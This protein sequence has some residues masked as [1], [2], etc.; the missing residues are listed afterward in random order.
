MNA[1]D[2]GAPPPGATV[3]Q[4]RRDVP[5]RDDVDVLVVGGGLGGVSAALAA[6]RAGA[7]TTLVERNGFPGGVATAGMCCSVFNCFYTADRRLGIMGNAVEITDALAE[8]SGVGKAWHDHKG[9]VIYDV[10]AAKLTLTELL[11]QAGVR[12]LFDTVVTDA[13][14]DGD[15]LCGVFVHSKSGC[16]AI[17]SAVTVDAS[18]DAD[19]AWLAG[20]PLREMGRKA[21]HSYCF[22][23]GNVDVDAFVQY[24]VEHPDQYPD[25]MDVDWTFAEALEQYRATGTFLFPHG[26]GYQMDLFK[27]AVAS[28]ELPATV[29]MHDTIPACQMHAIRE[30]GVVHVIT[31][32]VTMDTMDV[33]TISRAMS[34]GKRMAFVVRDFFRQNVPGFARSCVIGLADDLGMRATRWIEGEF[35]FTRG[36]KENPTRFDDAI[37]RGVVERDVRKHQ[38]DDAWGVQTFTDATFDVPYRCLLPKQIDGLLMGAGRSISAE[39]PMLLRVMALT[40]VI[41]Q[42]AGVAA[43]VA[44]R[45]GVVPRQADVRTVQDELRRQGVVLDA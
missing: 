2:K 10:E 6:A 38:A 5:V 3:A 45:A 9:H 19:V 12:L 35:E 30:L 21:P 28:G 17:R 26:G 44:A 14:V 13:L 8:T 41:G 27:R 40:M 36:M 43:A 7:R 20:A 25:Y 33:A 29:G 11:E 23:M 37:G 32:F 22:R 31:G 24:F 4:P 16:E 18:G 15:V 42:G 39:N 1:T 34:D